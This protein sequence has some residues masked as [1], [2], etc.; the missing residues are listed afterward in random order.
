M[1]PAKFE[2]HC[3]G[4]NRSG[5]T[6]TQLIC[7]TTTS[8]LTTPIINRI[9]EITVRFTGSISLVPRANARD[10]E[11]NE[12]GRVTLEVHDTRPGTIQPTVLN[13]FL[14]I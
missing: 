3:P 14:G 9:G 13:Q 1:D 11:W 12:S 8:S 10:G 2:T 4:L 6:V 7:P 5:K